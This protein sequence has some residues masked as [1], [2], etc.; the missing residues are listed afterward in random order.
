MSLRAV[1]YSRRDLLRALVRPASMWTAPDAVRPPFCADA[2]LFSRCRTCSA[3]PCAAACPEQII[4]SDSA[5]IPY[6][7][8]SRHGCTSC[9]ECAAA[10]DRA[11]LFP[12]LPGGIQ[13]RLVLDTDQCLGWRRTLCLTCAE[14]CPDKAVE[15]PVGLEPEVDAALCT[16]CGLCVAVCPVDALT[17]NPRDEA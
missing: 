12:D 3:K 16:R 15:A 14:I 8:F 7:D 11:V 5:G 10:C 1:R 2:R 6:L 17:V 4:E 13:G 9:G